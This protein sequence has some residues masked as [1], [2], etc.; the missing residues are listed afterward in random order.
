MNKISLDEAKYETLLNDPSLSEQQRSL[1]A[2]LLE[3]AGQ[4]SAENTR[5]RRVLLKKSSGG[6]RMSSKLKDALYE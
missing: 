5:L 4:L 2:E 6:Q 3:T 1:I